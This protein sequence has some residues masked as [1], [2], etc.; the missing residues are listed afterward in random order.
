LALFALAIAVPA[1][2]R[3]SLQP[4]PPSGKARKVTPAP[5]PAPEKPAIV[6][7]VVGPVSYTD[8]F[9]DP[10]PQGRHEGNDIVAPKRALA[11]AAEAGNVK[12]WTTS[13]A[14][15]CMLYLHGKSGTTYLYVH[16][17]NDVTLKNDN[18]GKCVAGTSYAK[19]L[20]DGQAVAAGQP[21]GYVGDSGD[22]DGVHPHLHFEVHPDGK[23]AVDPYP[24]LQK[25]RHLLFAANPSDL[26]SLSLTGSLVAAP[27]AKLDVKVDS[28]RAS[29]G[30]R[31]AKVGRTVRLA[32]PTSTLIEWQGGIPIAKASLARFAKGQSLTAYTVPGLPTLAAQLG[33]PG[34]LATEKIAFVP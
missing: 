30:L 23:A 2:A 34:A 11:V 18:R 12:F 27:P 26:V 8:D 25:A 32:V 19:G 3:P 21:V 33:E 13:I 1:A 24:Y 4:D 5:K 15:G 10:R 17:N 28:L 9:G 6:F 20:R 22:A 7:P 14:A 29:T 31:I 16:L